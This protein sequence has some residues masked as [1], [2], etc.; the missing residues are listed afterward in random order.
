[1]MISYHLGRD[2]IAWLIEKNNFFSLLASQ[3]EDL[4]EV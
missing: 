4:Q 3:W 1:M 2:K